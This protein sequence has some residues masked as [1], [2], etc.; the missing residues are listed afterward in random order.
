MEPSGKRQAAA[1]WG[2]PLG[3]EVK[4]KRPFE[5]KKGKWKGGGSVP[6]LGA[7]SQGTPPVRGRLD[8]HPEES[9]SRKKG[10]LKRGTHNRVRGK[11]DRSMYK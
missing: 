2:L 5:R 3:E 7:L 9:L 6:Q 1:A 8:A 10:D 4:H 11:Y